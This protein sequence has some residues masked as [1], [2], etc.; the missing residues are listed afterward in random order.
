MKNKIIVMLF[1]GGLFILLILAGLPSPASAHHSPACLITRAKDSPKLPS[2]TSAQAPEEKLFEIKARNFVFTPN[3]IQVNQGD[4]VRIRLISEDVH[5]GLYLDGYEIQTSALPGQEGTLTFVANKTGRF[6]FRCS[7][8]CGEFHPY[9]VGYLVVEPNS[10]F[11]IYVFL[12]IALA[13]ANLA[14]VVLR[15]S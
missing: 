3:V 5:H 10:P 13:L 12:T 7:V 14:F 6:T 11:F 2:P 8:T 1:L 9:M 4:L 15:R